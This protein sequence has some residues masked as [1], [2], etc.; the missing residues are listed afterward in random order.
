VLE[1]EETAKR[2]SQALAT[3]LASLDSRS[4][5]ILEARWL[6]DKKTATLDEL[7]REFGITAER[8]RQLEAKALA[9]L[10][11]TVAAGA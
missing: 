7:G 2:L 5:R 6:T 9:K 11:T 10:K 4:R 8:V 3:A 1:Q